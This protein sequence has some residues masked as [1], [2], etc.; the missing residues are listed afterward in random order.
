MLDR[1]ELLIIDP[2]NDFCEKGPDVEN[3]EGQ[4]ITQTAP[5]N[6]NLAHMPYQG[7]L[8]VP[9]A[10]QDMIRLAAMIDRLGRKLNDIH[11]TLD[12]HHYFSI[13]HPIFLLDRNGNHP[14]PFTG[15]TYKDIVDGVYR[16]CVDSLQEWL[17]YYTKTL[18]DNGRYP[19]VIWPYHCVIQTPGSC[20]YP[21]L[22]D[23]LLR[24]E[25]RPGIV[26]KVVKGSNYK[27]EHYSA[28]QAEV[29]DPE[30]KGTMLNT[31]LI[32]T[33]ER[34]DL[35]PVGGEASN[36]CVMHTIMDIIKQFGE[37]AARKFVILTDAMSPV[38]GFEDKQE[39]FMS[40]MRRMKVQF[41]TTVDFLA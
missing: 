30:D 28:V 24:W 11:V 13:F 2:N 38:P 15:I 27:T 9:G 35:I 16:A 32:S 36:F 20:I 7:S 10:D 25:S 29:I 8:Y 1:I 40:E 19:Y 18:D 34:A 14:A 41:S 12:S 37:D 5:K 23:A 3:I 33:L 31:K 6:N 21:E 22:L 4:R 39:L 17:E 26:D